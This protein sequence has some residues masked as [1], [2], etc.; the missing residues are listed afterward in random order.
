MKIEELRN[1]LR[2]RGLKVTEKKETLIAA[3]FCAI[4]NNVTLVKTAQEVEAQLKEENSEKL[5]FE[6]S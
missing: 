5:E 2:L 6:T 4:G 1:F 3:A